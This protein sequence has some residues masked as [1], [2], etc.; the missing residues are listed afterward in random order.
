MNEHVAL[1]SENAVF[2]FNSHAPPWFI[3]SLF[4]WFC[5]FLAAHWEQPP[6]LSNKTLLKRANIPAKDLLIFYLTC[7]RPVTEYACPVFH[8]VLPAHLSAENT[9]NLKWRRRY[10][11]CLCKNLCSVIYFYNI[12][13]LTLFQYLTRGHMNRWNKKLKDNYHKRK[14]KQAKTNKQ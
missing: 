9:T 10:F 8:N 5:L 11:T 12:H 13:P 6:H 14:R 3:I 2:S 4:S 7:I 1:I